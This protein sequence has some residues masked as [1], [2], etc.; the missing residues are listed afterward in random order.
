MVNEK[1]FGTIEQLMVT[2][3]K[4]HEIMLAKVLPMMVVFLIAAFISIYTIMVPLG[5]PI[6]GNVLEFLLVTVVFCFTASGLGLLVSTISNNLSETVLLTLLLLFPIMFLSG[7]WVPPE[8]MPVWMRFFVNLSP[9][10]YYLDLGFGIF[11]KGNNLLFMWKEF[12]S[13]LVLGIIIFWIGAQRFKK[14]FG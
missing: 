9:L 7:T 12:V 3:V 8:A 2:P 13:L 1:Q 4:P 11:L 10:K 14:M 6:R 5:I